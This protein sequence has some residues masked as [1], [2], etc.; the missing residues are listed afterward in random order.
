MIIIAV[1]L[2]ERSR[3]PGGKSVKKIITNGRSVYRKIN[4]HTTQLTHAHTY[5]H[6]HTKSYVI[7]FFQAT[8]KVIKITYSPRILLFQSSNKSSLYKIIR[9]CLTHNTPT[10]HTHTLPSFLLISLSSF[11]PFKKR[12]NVCPAIH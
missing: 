9:H 6:T 11:L 5:T 10:P 1:E 4:T 8:T 12:L 2:T 3:R 7:P